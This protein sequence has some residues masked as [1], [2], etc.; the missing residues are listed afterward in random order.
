MQFLA[1]CP[2]YKNFQTS[3]E[4][5]PVRIYAHGD[6]GSPVLSISGSMSVAFKPPHLRWLKTKKIR[7]DERVKYVS[8]EFLVI[9]H[10]RVDITPV[11]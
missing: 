8:G 1:E 3:I 9:F 2:I 7:E 11:H 5:A 6:S 10:E 4:H